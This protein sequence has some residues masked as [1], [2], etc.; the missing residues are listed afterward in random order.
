MAPLPD[1]AD[2]VVVGA[3]LAGLRAAR[4]LTAGGA[5]VVV[6]EARDRVGGRTLSVPVGRGT[7]DLGAQWL[8]PGQDRVAALARELGAAT[9]PTYHQG[10]KVLD[11]QGRVTTYKGSI[12]SLPLPSLVRMHLIIRR[13]DRMARAVPLHNPAAARRAAVWD[14]LSL[15]AWKRSHVGSPA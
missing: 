9:F 3:G 12:P 1:R 15:E 13:L 8:G 10:A 2:V 5:S 7:F 4:D 6:L 14:G 11:L